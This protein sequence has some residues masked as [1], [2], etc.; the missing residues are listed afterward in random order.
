MSYE[1]LVQHFR[2][3]LEGLST[4]EKGRRFAHLVQRL[5]TQTDIGAAY[6]P[7]ET[8]PTFSND[9]GVD[10][11]AQSRGGKG[12]LYTQ[13]KLWLDRAEDFDS[14]LSKFEAYLT[15]HHTEGAAGQY[16]LGFDDRSVSFCIVTLSK[17]QNV[18]QRYK[19][20]HLLRPPVN[21]GAPD[22]GLLIDP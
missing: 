15:K 1:A 8:S 7:P 6:F 16:E 14:V 18:V 9:E 5:I 13:A 10:L 3:Q 12:V 21:R 11:T 17:I 2:A 22:R 20:K 19:A 4:S